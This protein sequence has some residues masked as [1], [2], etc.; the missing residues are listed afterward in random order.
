MRLLES[1]PAAQGAGITRSLPV[2]SARVRPS[3]SAGGRTTTH[4]ARSCPLPYKVRAIGNESLVLR[5]P[6]RRD[7]A[8]RRVADGPTVSPR[9]PPRFTRS[10]SLMACGG[11]F[12]PTPI[13]WRRKFSGSWAVTSRNGL[14]HKG[15]TKATYSPLLDADGLTPC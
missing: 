8:H 10:L 15:A 14:I 1:S 7:L 4:F 12:G 13:R 9:P 3:K 6:Q 5:A 2:A 11:G